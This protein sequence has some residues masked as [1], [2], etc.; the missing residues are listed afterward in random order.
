MITRIDSNIFIYACM[1]KKILRHDGEF[2]LAG[3]I[4]SL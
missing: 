1:Q 4:C 2:S 3:S